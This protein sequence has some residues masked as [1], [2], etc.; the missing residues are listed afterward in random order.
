MRVIHCI[1]QIKKA[2]ERTCGAAALQMVYE[3]I[4]GLSLTQEEIWE[5]IKAPDGRGGMYATARDVASD[6]HDRKLNVMI[7][8]S[9]ITLNLLKH[10]DDDNVAI[11]T[12][13]SVSP[14]DKCGHFRV[15]S[16]FNGEKIV[17][18]DPS[19]GSLV[20]LSL[21]E[22]IELWRKKGNGEVTGFIALVISRGETSQYTCPVC[23]RIVPLTVK[24]GVCGNVNKLVPGSV[25]GCSNTQCPEVN[26]QHVI[27]TFCNA[28]LARIS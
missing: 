22:F 25:L 1:E 3:G 8:R 28:P 12:I 5:K 19:S 26:W 15:V 4:F 6:V 14:T 2:G 11:I 16:D 10:C 18:C 9:S 17:L 13:A 20:S 24:C 23:K 27:C 7:I 21:G